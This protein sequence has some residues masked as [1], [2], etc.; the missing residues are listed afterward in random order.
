[1]M[2]KLVTTGVLAG[3]LAL[4]SVG[5]AGAATPSGSTA[6]GRH[7]TCAKAP[8]ALAKLHSLEA[9]GAT[10]VSQAQA[11]Q[12]SLSQDGFTKAAARVGHKIQRLQKVEAKAPALVQRIQ[13]RCPGAT[14]A[15]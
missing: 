6:G 14:P 11:L 10:L 1:M 13:A 12:Q 3:A 4:G 8:E 15:S 7:F 5:V 2:R 9:N